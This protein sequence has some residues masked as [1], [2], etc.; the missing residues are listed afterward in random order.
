MKIFHFYIFI[1]ILIIVGCS[2]N[3]VVSPIESFPNSLKEIPR[4]EKKPFPLQPS[5]PPPSEYK[6]PAPGDIFTISNKQ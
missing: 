6:L 3:K 4:I 1:L 5:R 2:R